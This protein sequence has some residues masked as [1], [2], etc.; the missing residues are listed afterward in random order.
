MH[1]DRADEV[2]LDGELLHY[3][4]MPY[5]D[6]RTLEQA[7]DAGETWTVPQALEVAAQIADG[8]AALQRS[9][10]STATSSPR[11]SCTALTGAFRSST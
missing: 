2:E 1:I 9:E 7:M 6:G 11:T 4:V 8:L 3:V 5:V 10:G